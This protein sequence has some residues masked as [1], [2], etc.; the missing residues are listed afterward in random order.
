[1]LSP[2]NPIIYTQSDCNLA[3]FSPKGENK[4]DV[5]MLKSGG[6]CECTKGSLTSHTENSFLSAQAGRM[7]KN[8]CKCSLSVSLFCSANSQCCMFFLG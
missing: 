7:T 2:R 1:M 8:S 3:A 4:R 5:L 6:I